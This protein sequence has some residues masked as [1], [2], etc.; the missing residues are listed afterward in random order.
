MSLLDLQREFRSAVLGRPFNIEAR[1]A[2]KCANGLAV[3]RNAYR[4]RLR[5]CLRETYEKS[6]AW[7]GD[8]RF[9][10]AI[11]RYVSANRPRSWTLADFGEGVADAF[12]VDLQDDPEASELAWLDW[13]MRRAFDGADVVPLRAAQSHA[14]DWD[15][16]ALQFAPTLALRAVATNSGAIWAAISEGNTPPEVEMLPSAAALCVWRKDLSP[17]FRTI[18][19]AELQALRLALAGAPFGEICRL[20]AAGR[21][22]A[23]AVAGLGQILARWIEDAML[24]APSTE[25]SAGEA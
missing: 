25:G 12:A 23:D 14:I 22:D 8:A 16:A 15:L 21:S 2:G 6:W 3:Y 5:D 9:D 11:D 13:A 18:Q 1:L 17:R 20:V 24:I 7:L 4:L 19:G 10:A